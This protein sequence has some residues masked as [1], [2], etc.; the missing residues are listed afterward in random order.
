MQPGGTPDMANLMKQAQQMQQQMA[1]AQQELD[2][3]EVTG[4]AGGGVI[5]A[6]VTG[7]GELKSMTIDPSVVDPA[8]T[9][10]LADLVVAAVR[11]ATASATKLAN[12]KLGPV[13]GSLGL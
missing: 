5:S 8:D 1:A 6:V 7:N 9:E 4:T 3:T 12:E 2:A 10:T 13:A 11:D